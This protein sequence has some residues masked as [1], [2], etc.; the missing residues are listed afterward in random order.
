MLS[1]VTVPDKRD[2][3]RQNRKRRKTHS[4]QKMTIDHDST[5]LAHR[6]IASCLSVHTFSGVKNAD[7]MPSEPF[8]NS[9]SIRS[10]Y[11]NG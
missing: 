1:F 3:F 4:S 8:R 7:F 9:T 11:V 10:G 2:H 6:Y 5:F